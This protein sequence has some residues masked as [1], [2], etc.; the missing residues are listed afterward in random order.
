MPR[1]IDDLRRGPLNMPWF[2][3]PDKEDK[4]EADARKIVDLLRADMPVIHIPNVAEYFFQSD[5]EFWDL[6]RDFPNLAPPYTQFFS[7][8]PLPNKI[9]SKEKG[10]TDISDHF[11]GGRTG[12]L[13]TAL[14]PKEGIVIAEGKPHD[15]CHWILW[16]ELFID[17]ARRGIAADGPHGSI[18]LMVD[19]N[20]AVLERPWM[21]TLTGG[22]HADIMCNLMTSVNPTFLAVCFMHC[23]NVRIVDNQV[24][25]K[26][27]KRYRER[28]GGQTPSPYKTLIIDPLKQILKREGNA[29]R[30]GLARAMHICRGHFRDYR[31]GPGLFGKYHQLV[32]SPMTVRGN[33]GK[34]V[35]DRDVE[36]KLK[37]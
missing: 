7:E 22:Q 27:A 29:D 1:F 31:T 5:Q 37:L 23:R 32:W 6:R 18:F 17:Y 15:D 20:G 19:K 24:D 33:K 16:C 13:V 34:A 36:V 30:V 35:R 25:A 9:Y 12:V 4:W 28:H 10:T 3:P 21:Q 14:D 26:L 11:A 8:H 2:I